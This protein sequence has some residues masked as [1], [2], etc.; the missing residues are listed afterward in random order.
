MRRTKVWDPLV[1]IFHWSLAGVFIANA[2]AVD[3]DARLH[4]TLGYV[5]LGLV[6]FRVLWGLIGARHARFS[7]FPPS[8]TAA[9]GQIGEV[10]T[11]RVRHHLGHTPLGALMIYNLLGTL[12]LIALSGWLMTTDAFWGQEWPEEFHEIMVTWAE[13][14]VV[15]HVG[16]VIFESMR[17]RVN[18]PLSM[19]TGYK[20]LPD[21]TQR[22]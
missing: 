19:I 21:T 10:A 13:A 9:M 18:L 4:Q 22:P 17:S 1:R 15:I 8:L 2:I 12:V 16:A 7:D 20:N 11:G 3:P 14:S 6:V 5:A